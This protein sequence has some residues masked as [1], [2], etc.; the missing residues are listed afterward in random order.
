MGIFS[1]R[2]G[3]RSEGVAQCKPALISCKLVTL[4][5]SSFSVSALCGVSTTERRFFDAH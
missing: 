1:K 3:A 2:R 5:Q 4:D